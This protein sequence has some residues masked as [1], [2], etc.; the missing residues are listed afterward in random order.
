MIKKRPQRTGSVEI[1]GVVTLSVIN[2]LSTGMLGITLAV[3]ASFQ[4]AAQS[5]SPAPSPWA[6]PYA[7][8]F[9]GGAGHVADWTE[10]NDDW[11]DGTRTARSIGVLGGLYAG[12]GMT[13]GRFVYGVE[14]DFGLSS[15]GTTGPLEG[16]Y[17]DVETNKI[18]WLSSIRARAGV[19]ESGLLFYATGGLAVG[20]FDTFM[21]SVDYS[22]E[23]YTANGV[24]VGWVAGVGVE[25]PIYE[26]VSLRV[27]ALYYGF[28]GKTYSQLDDDD[29]NTIQNSVFTGRIGLSVHF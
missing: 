19:V 28:R 24:R 27:E 1:Q 29:T 16:E 4:A 17:D 25:A 10:N 11:W 8:A 23:V 20:D 9:L 3:G 12:Y 14:A 21:T 18:V 13:A 2:A 15:N 7:G 22:D 5:A 26:A 6:G